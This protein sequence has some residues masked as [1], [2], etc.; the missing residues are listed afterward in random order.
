MSPPYYPQVKKETS[1]GEKRRGCGKN[2]APS[3]EVEEGAPVGPTP[4]DPAQAYQTTY[5]VNAADTQQNFLSYAEN[6]KTQP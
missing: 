2:V 6:V 1:E 3:T 5:A 4:I